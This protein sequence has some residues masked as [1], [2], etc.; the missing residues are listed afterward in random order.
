MPV[1]LRLP[2]RLTLSVVIRLLIGIFVAVLFSASSAFA[3]DKY[4][5][6]DA[7]NGKNYTEAL[8][9]CRPLA[10][11]GEVNAQNVLGSMYL[12]GRGVSQND[13]EAAKWLR[14]AAEQGDPWSHSA[15][16]VLGT[17]YE[18][19]HGVPQDYVLAYMWYNLGGAET[20][21]DDLAAKMTPDQIAEA[22]RLTRGWRPTK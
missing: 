16:S 7:F 3:G 5:C 18:D 12:K 2:N 10:E 21:R 9:L 22:Q 4:D 15:Q 20:A 8:R 11:Q 14:K 1:E 19:G 17:L 6:L 13:F